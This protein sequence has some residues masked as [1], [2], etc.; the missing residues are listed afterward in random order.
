MGLSSIPAV[1]GERLSSL[2]SDKVKPLF[3]RVSMA[4]WVLIFVY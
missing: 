2:L 3:F 4:A 1:I